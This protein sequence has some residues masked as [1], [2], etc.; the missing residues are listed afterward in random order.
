MRSMAEMGIVV[1]D[2]TTRCAFQCSGCTRMIGHV[3]VRD[4]DLETFKKAVDALEG[5]PGMIGVIGGEPLLWPHFEAATEYLVAKTG[6]PDRRNNLN[7]PIRD[8]TDFL[9][10]NYGELRV[11][12][13]LFTSLPPNTIRHWEQILESYQY[14]GFNTHENAGLHQQILVAS[15]EL[16]LKDE[17]RRQKISECWVNKLWSASITPQGC[18]PCEVM[19]TLAHAFDGPGPTE[20]WSIEKDWWKRP[21]KDWGDMLKWCD[22]CGAAMDVPRLLSTDK[23]EIVSPANYERLKKMGSRK[24]ARG[25]V[26]IFDL[27]TCDLTKYKAEKH[28]NWYL[29]TKDDNKPD[30]TSRASSANNLKP[31][32][33]EGVVFCSGRPSILA[34][35]LPWNLKHW[36]KVVVVALAENARCSEIASK[37]G[38]RYIVAKDSVLDVAQSSLELHDWAAFV[39]DDILL[40][41]N[42]RE[43]FNKY[44]WNPG[45][46][47]SFTRTHSS[48]ENAVQQIEGGGQG[49][50][51]HGTLS[52]SA[53]LNQQYR[54]Y[55]QLFHTSAKSLRSSENVVG[56]GSRWTDNKKYLINLGVV[57]ILAPKR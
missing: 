6:G 43:V 54:G 13:G 9:L 40:P 17:E 55:F 36:D 44:V 39:D 16:P 47:Y 37:H 30:L 34:I 32:K 19:G 41:S 26:K 45:V 23:T 42:F 51:F 24:V 28:V 12:R 14:I 22:I 50:L 33:L 31:R 10:V 48:L 27:A 4:M 56:L 35:T 1:I 52:G 8:L 57:Q 2:V 46:L 21:V 3:P 38:I 53:S 49:L 20:G 29:P 7:T 25:D 15:N 11:K 18:W 5:H